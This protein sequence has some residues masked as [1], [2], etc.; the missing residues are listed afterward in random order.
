MNFLKSLTALCVLLPLGMSAQTFRE[1]QDPQVNELN[2]L[3]MRTR[4]FTYEDESIA[5][6]GNMAHSSR[7]VSLHG[8]WKFKG[9]QNADEYPEDFYKQDYNDSDWGSMPIP[10]M[11]EL[12]G[13]GDPVYLNVGYAWRGHFTNQPL[14]KDPTPVKDNRVGS[15]RKVINVPAD[16]KGNPIY[17]YI[18]SV[19]SNAYIWINGQF[20]GY[21]EDSKLEAEFDV[22]PYIKPGEENLIAFRVFRWCDGSYLEDQ[23]FFRLSGFARDTYLYTRP[24][25]HITDV[26]VQQDLDN[27]YQDGRLQLEIFATGK[28]EV[29]ATLYTPDNK[30]V[31]DYTT[32]GE[33]VNSLTAK[34]PQVKAWSAEEPN[35]YKLVLKT[36]KNGGLSEVIPM[37][38][39]FRKVEMKGGLLLFNGKP[40]K[41]K[42]A[43]RH[44]IDPE[45]GYVVSRE[46][47]EQDIAI[48][49]QLN[50]NGV[51]TCHY[52]NDPYLYDLCDRYGLYVIS[53]TNIESHGMGYGKESLAKQPLWEKS[54]VERNLRHVISRGHHPSIVIWSMSNEA[55]DGSNFTRTYSEIKKIDTSRPVMLERAEG[56]PN[57]DIHCPMYRSQEGCREYAL[58]NPSKPMILCEYAHAMGNSL[59][60][61]REYMDV[62]H[63]FDCLQGGYIWDF[64]DQSLYAVRDGV[65]I[66]AYGGDYNSYDPSD[67]NFCDNG[68]I[69]PDRS[70]NPHAHE[71]RHGYQ[72]IRTS[73]EMSGTNATLKVHNDN[74]F[75][76]LRDLRIRID[77]VVE[78]DIASTTRIPCPE[79]A[80]QETAE[81]PLSLPAQMTSGDHMLNIS[82]ETT[83]DRP[84]MHKGWALAQDQL[85]LHTQKDR[86][87]TLSAS[88][89]AVRLDRQDAGTARFLVGADL[90]VSFDTTTGFLTEYR[91]EGRDYLTPQTSL[92]PLFYRAPTD[93]DMGANL[94]RKWEGWR[95]PKY[96]LQKLTFDIVDGRGYAEAQYQMPSTGAT[97]H[98]S[99]LIDKDG[100]IIY[101]QRMIKG[102][103]E[104]APKYMFRYGM[105]LAMPKD[106]SYVSYYGRGPLENYVDRQTNCLIGKYT[107]SV[108]DQFY[109]Y[110]RPQET[111][112][113]SD[114]RYWM[115]V[116]KNGDGLGFIANEPLYA[117]TLEYS[118]ES[119]D[120]YPKKRNMH[121]ELVKKDPTSQHVQIDWL[122]M[123]L[124][125]INS[126]GEL[127][128]TKYL[129]PYQDYDKTLTIYP[130]SGISVGR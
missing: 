76:P 50:I 44:E 125:T 109:S 45:G 116:D 23:D 62:F 66:R 16:W 74:Y 17:L 95:Q 59:G 39:G 38:V 15:Y 119:L 21:T 69:A 37:N 104:G 126:W 114:V 83:T 107:S 85:V 47:M 27:N 122:H 24:V 14:A 117:S 41:F 79:V 9:V 26:K 22:S 18:G 52:P 118:I 99:Y 36:F 53:E 100:K 20:V 84:F 35:L 42:G 97:L 87:P 77:Y 10:G 78:G 111:G 115:V 8:Q 46:R 98:L 65:R 128:L 81:V 106:F 4:F 61:F 54:H 2:R 43:N 68:L 103:K 6:S 129:V 55:G 19:T 120:E 70:L 90:I 82:Y 130:V 28:P 51:R 60:S 121:T 29:Q 72:P 101:R 94:Q 57:S 71:A 11:W 91:L 30:I 88:G 40:V 96:D 127:P 113:K 31:W 67:D 123:G 112:L 34:I 89:I 102:T 7:V 32:K 110:I 5:K 124:G 48:M 12:N 93:N 58:S 64:V 108:E 73:L 1:W 105:Q 33:K 92:T 3:P 13:F 63:E 86:M 75:T 80:P 49:K 56:G 25:A